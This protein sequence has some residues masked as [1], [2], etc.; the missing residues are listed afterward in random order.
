M[1]HFFITKH[2][3]PQHTSLKLDH[4]VHTFHSVE[5]EKND[6]SLLL[7]SGGGGYFKGG[8]LIR[9]LD[10]FISQFEIYKVQGIESNCHKL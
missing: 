6:D 5:F 2:L 4:K 8:D 7:V 10:Y 1:K 3:P 9:N